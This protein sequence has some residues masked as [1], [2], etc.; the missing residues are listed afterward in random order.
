MKL[1]INKRKIVKNYKVRNFV[2]DAERARRALES[3]QQSLESKDWPLKGKTIEEIVAA[4]KQTR[5]KLW[6]KRFAYRP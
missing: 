2:P 3:L 5:Y 6:E 4:V 1:K